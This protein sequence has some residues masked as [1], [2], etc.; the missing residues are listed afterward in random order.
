MD[1]MENRLVILAL[2]VD[3]EPLCQSLISELEAVEAKFP[4]VAFFQLD[5]SKAPVIAAQLNLANVPAVYAWR[6]GNLRWAKT[7]MPPENQLENELSE[8]LASE[9]Q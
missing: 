1:V 8:W 2:V 7:G 3:D 4:Q 9:Q 5:A 6:D